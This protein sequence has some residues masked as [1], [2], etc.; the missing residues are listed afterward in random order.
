LIAIPASHI[1]FQKPFVFSK[2][3]PKIHEHD[4]KR[5]EALAIIIDGRIA[6]LYTHETD[7]GDGWEDQEVHHDPEEVRDTAL[8]MG[9]NIIHYVFNN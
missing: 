7:L 6:L 5:P 3:I 1:L 2:G 8:K 4:G 9:A